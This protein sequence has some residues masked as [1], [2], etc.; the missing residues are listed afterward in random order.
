MHVRSIAAVLGVAA[1][2]AV[3]A[4]AQ[5]APVPADAT[6]SEA[7]FDTPEG[8]KL[9]ADVFRPKSV[10][11]S[12]KLPVVMVV[13]PYTGHSA[14]MGTNFDPQ[15]SG[16]SNRFFDFANGAK[17]FTREHKYT[18]VVV[19]L[20]GFG[21]SGGCTDWGGPNEQNAVRYAVEWAAKEPWSTGKVGLYGKSYDGWTGLMGIAQHPKGLAAVVSA[22]P[23]YS[24]YDYLYM[25]GIRFGQSTSMGTTFGQTNLQPGTVNDTTDYQ[26]SGAPTTPWCVG[27][28]A[29]MQQQ[30][31]KNAGFWQVRELAPAVRGATTPLLMTQGF[32]ED[33]TKPDGAFAFFENMAGP[34]RAWFGEWD[35]VRGNDTVGT[36]ANAKLAMG[37]PGWFDEVMSFYDQYLLGIEPSVAYPPIALQDGT[38]RWR[39]EQ[40]WPP[41]DSHRLVT[42]L[43][44][45]TYVDD[46]NN[47]GT[48]PNAGKGIWTISEPL[49]HD[50]HFAGEPAIT[51]DAAAALP[52]A[53]LVADVYAIDPAGK[54]TLISRGGKLIRSSGIQTITL[55]GNDWPIDKGSR[56]GVLITGA[57]SEW[58]THTATQQTVTVNAARIALPFLAH[59]RTHDQPGTSSAKLNAYKASAPFT[60][61]ATT[62]TAATAPFTLPEPLQP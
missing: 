1:A 10:P 55:Y 35:H 43:K 17:L 44:T 9:H 16:P 7:Y 39:S 8:Y 4:A 59:K 24:G 62:I 51:V 42:E 60:V 2:L 21:G 22:E 45:G 56:L 47:S 30:D 27:V 57:N 40:Q 46:D 38:G 13:S 58:F 15:A 61:P 29:L 26:L 23:V 50:V 41:A 53:N 52:N 49:P 20:P 6:W 28:N 5:A 31:D 25:D 11:A 32:L 34:K 3:P 14:P 48:G 36:G 19:D 12:E 54:A 37:R 33:N 18:F